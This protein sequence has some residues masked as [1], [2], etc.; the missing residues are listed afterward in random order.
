VAVGVI[1]DQQDRFLIARRPDHLHQG[2]LW[3]FPGGK[4]A[5]GESVEDA[6]GRELHE[7]L[8]ITVSR[9]RRLIGVQH[10]YGDKRVHLDVWLVEAFTGRAHG[11]E[12]QPICW[13][14]RAELIDY[15]FPDA[16]RAILNCLR[17]PTRYLVTGAFDD[18][19]DLQRRLNA[20]LSSGIRLVQFRAPHLDEPAYA[21]FAEAVLEV[22][23]HYQASCLLNCDPRSAA[24][25]HADGVHLNSVRLMA[26]TSRPLP[27]SKWVAASVHNEQQLR[28]ARRIGCDF[29]VIGAVK[30]TASHPGVAP[31]G[32][33]A[34]EQLAQRAN[35]PCYALGG[36]GEADL[37]EAQRYG[38]QGVA[39]ISA[40]WPQTA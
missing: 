7:E 29:V 31:L 10:D 9:A 8:G 40:W 12:G 38:A 16:N 6:L 2:G 39:A 17:L 24:R 14:P 27:A 19:R 37:L 3:E 21:H 32:W 35:C 15:S 23:G 36:M 5:S 22:C 11:R 4:V 18:L 25:L 34:F 26:A 20:V 28:Q 33:A 1:R 30:P 13:V